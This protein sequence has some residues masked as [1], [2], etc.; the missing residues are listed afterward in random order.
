MG[1]YK[2][3]EGTEFFKDENGTLHH[4]DGG[5]MKPVVAD[6]STASGIIDPIPA[7]PP[8]EDDEFGMDFLG[9]KF[10]EGD[11]KVESGEISCNLDNPEDCE[12]CGS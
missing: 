9:D 12:A 11:K 10:K 6:L 7:Q 8:K 2:K 3:V 5:E 4:I 1:I